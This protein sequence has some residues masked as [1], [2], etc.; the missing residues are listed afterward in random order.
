MFA[1]WGRTVVRA[2][3]LVL[4][5]G[6]GVAVVG[7]LWG[8]WVFG[9][10][11]N[12]GFETPNSESDRAAT[13]IVKELGHSSVVA[14]GGLADLIIAECVSVQHH[15]PWLTLADGTEDALALAPSRTESTTSFAPPSARSTQ[16]SA[17]EFPV[18]TTSTS[19][20]RYGSALRYF[21]EWISSP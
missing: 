1:W 2:R 17:P 3:W 13:R 16:I 15:E 8:T 6:V 11:S 7:A 20:P 4:A 10:L 12:G 18:P 19:R 5:A 21:D 9:A 14:T